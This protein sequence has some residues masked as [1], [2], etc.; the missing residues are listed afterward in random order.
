MPRPSS[1][2]TGAGRPAVAA[3]T[4]RSDS[5]APSVRQPID[6]EESLDPLGVPLEVLGASP[7]LRP[8]DLG[9]AIVATSRT[10]RRHVPLRLDQPGLL[11][12]VQETV[13]DARLARR[14]SEAKALQPAADLI[15]VGATLVQDQQNERLR[16]PAKPGRIPVERL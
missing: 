2:S 14:P 9:Q 7:Q 16:I 13:D 15:A 8:T 12:A 6:L 11:E 4:A 3:V 1:S 5:L 10:A